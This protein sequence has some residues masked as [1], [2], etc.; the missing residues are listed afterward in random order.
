[1]CTPKND[2]ARQYKAHP[3]PPLCALA[4]QFWIGTNKKLESTMKWTCS[5]PFELPLS[6]CSSF[7]RRLGRFGAGNAL[8]LELIELDPA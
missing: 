6:T 1:M 3:Q 4:G 7:V 2:G 8:K 5:K